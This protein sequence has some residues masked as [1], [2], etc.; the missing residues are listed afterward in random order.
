MF[1]SLCL[2]FLVLVTF[3][4]GFS[5]QAQA[6][7]HRV[8]G[9]LVFYQDEIYT[10]EGE[11]VP[12]YYP[13][14]WDQNR[15]AIPHV[16]VKIYYKLGPA[17][18]KYKNTDF[19]TDASGCFDVEISSRTIPSETE[20]KVKF[21]L[22]DDKREVI[23]ENNKTYQYWSSVKASES[24]TVLDFGDVYSRHEK[25][26]GAM[27]MWL[28]TEETIR[29]HEEQIGPF[30]YAVRLIVKFP[31]PM[32]NAKA[33]A[34]FKTI[35]IPIESQPIEIF[36]HE[37]GHWLDNRLGISSRTERAVYCVN[38]ESL[39]F[40]FDH[41]PYTFYN[42]NDTQKSCPHGAFNYYE[43]AIALSE[44]FATF[45]AEVLYPETAFSAEKFL[46]HFDGIHS[47]SATIATLFDILD[48][49]PEQQ[50]AREFYIKQRDDLPNK[51]TA[52]WYFDDDPE[53]FFE[54]PQSTLKYLITS[55]EVAV[56]GIP[57]EDFAVMRFD[58]Q[59]QTEEKVADTRDFSRG[60]E[61]EAVRMTVSDDDQILCLLGSLP[62]EEGMDYRDAIYCGSPHSG[63]PFQKVKM[64]GLP[65][66][67]IHD[68]VLAEGKSE[69]QKQSQNQ[70]TLYALV[71][72]NGWKVLKKNLGDLRW[73]LVY[74]EEEENL[75]HKGSFD[76]QKIQSLA[77][78]KN[79]QKLYLARYF[80]VDSCL[81]ENC[82]PRREVGHYKN[83]GLR[84]DEKSQSHFRGIYNIQIAD[85]V[86]YISDHYGVTRTTL[87][88]NDPVESYIGNVYAPTFLNN[89]TPRSLN[90]Y[91]PARA[92]AYTNADE[93]WIE[94]EG[95]FFLFATT[96]DF[97]FLEGVINEWPSYEDQTDP[98][99]WFGDNS[100]KTQKSFMRYVF[101]KDQDVTEKYYC[102]SE[103][104]QMSL[105][106][107]LDT[108]DKKLPSS[109]IEDLVDK[110]DFTESEKQGLLNTN[111]IK[112]K[113]SDCEQHWQSPNRIQSYFDLD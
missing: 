6:A 73:T 80:Y 93:Y 102:G 56:Y 23:S 81:I 97:I 28:F 9:C 83:I 15:L 82:Q 8:K 91:E 34:T 16:P 31:Q 43:P 24:D 75:E 74:F 27:K 40:P 76:A 3:A 92:L 21:R 65:T 89:L 109:S 10:E 4:N 55:S 100:R 29:R 88:R 2:F 62:K 1:K 103:N 106:T 99:S 90:V 20:I 64:I 19:K 78:S 70:K 54:T 14:P 63:T 42:H 25:A 60:E 95:R 46:L 52:K 113:S 35:H 107:L 50:V 18:I 108:L 67:K 110:L 5:L 98:E 59:S 36:L 111:W 22:Q 51:E 39:S 112:I 45:I 17:W 47:G 77:V 66:Q 26:V 11:E 58:P 104:V 13:L 68:V 72:E 30:E 32:D 38:K 53:I 57:N 37:F 12:N 7:S 101:K 79:Q 94:N 41:P 49:G 69:L 61:F 44:G 85:D 48:A 33:Y 84:Y 105:S 96:E 71:Y 87:N 86:L